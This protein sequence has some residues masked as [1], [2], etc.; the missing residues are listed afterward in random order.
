[1]IRLSC[2]Q[3]GHMLEIDAAFAGGVCRCQSCGTIQT[4]PRRAVRG[5][6]PRPER[7]AAS[8]PPVARTATRQPADGRLMLAV[9]M[10]AML[11]LVCAAL[12]LAFLEREH[13][14]E[15]PRGEAWACVC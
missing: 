8:G 3:C 2:A 6:P 1:M 9:A 11:A 10:A 14:A 15:A 5:Q 12:A 7:L 13:R 4:V